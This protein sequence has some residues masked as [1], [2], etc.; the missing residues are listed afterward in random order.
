MSDRSR[1]AGFTLLEVTLALTALALMAAICYGAFHL[2]I[3]A[4]ERGEVVVKTAERMRIASDILTRQM[5]SIVRYPAYERESEEAY[6]YVLGGPTWL[7]FITTAG[8]QGGGGLARVTY[9]VVDDERCVVPPCLIVSESRAFTPNSLAE[10]GLDTTGEA[11]TVLLEGFSSAGFAFYHDETGWKSSWNP[12]SGDD[13]EGLMPAA[14]RVVVE[15]LPGMEADVGGQVLAWGGERPV[16]VGVFNT[17]SLD[18]SDE[19]WEEF[20]IGVAES[21]DDDEADDKADEGDE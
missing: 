3:R 13:E 19:D 6:P 4:V 18:A 17:S 11:S 15:G 20:G 9:Q 1:A 16:M 21:E 14:V 8:Q 12:R 2:G 5:K 7:T 10:G